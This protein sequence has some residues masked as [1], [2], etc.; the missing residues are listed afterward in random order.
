M[1]IIL[2]PDSFKGTFSAPEVCRA[3]EKGIR[4]VLSEVEVAHLPLADGGEG[5]LDVLLAATG[6]RRCKTSA[7]DPL[8]R[9]IKVEFGVLSGSSEALVEMAGVSGLALLAEN[10]RN[11][12]K[13]GTYGLGQVVKAALSEGVAS[14]G[15]TLGGSATVDG[16]VGMARAL[17]FRFLDTD[18]SPLEFEGGGILG[19]IYRIDTD[20]VDPRLPTLRSRALCDVKNPL[21]GPLGAARVFGPQKGADPEMVEKL[22]EGL[23]NLAGRVEQDLGKK[24][25]DLPGSGA[26]GG[27]G[28]ATVAFLGGSLVPGIEYILETIGFAESL[29]GADLVLTGEGSFDSQSLGGKV[30]SGV[31]ELAGKKNV[32][33]V[34]VCGRYKKGENPAEQAGNSKDFLPEAVFSGADLARPADESRIVGLEGLAELAGRSAWWLVERRGK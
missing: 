2:A 15:L 11:P 17:G 6:G 32:P 12:W 5:T 31:L 24:V 33:V 10:E 27:L 21:L 30:I 28:A 25:A 1:K 22:E 34:V 23:A 7:A 16:G 18:G 4:Q 9:E 3:F 13:V 26:A 29:E 14:L 19:Q 8:G 20:K